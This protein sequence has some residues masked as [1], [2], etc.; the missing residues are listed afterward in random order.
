MKATKS[1][2]WTNW[3][4]LFLGMWVFVSPW[5][6]E[7]PEDAPIAWSNFHLIGAGLVVLAIRAIYFPQAWVLWAIAACGG[8]LAISPWSL[9]FADHVSQ[10]AHSIIAGVIAVSLS[11]PRIYRRKGN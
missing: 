1:L 2:P 4:I 11:A 8:W 5:I 7:I 6:V 10:T 9:G 3:A